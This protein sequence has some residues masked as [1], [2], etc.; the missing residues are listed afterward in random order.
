MK[1]FRKNSISWKQLTFYVEIDNEFISNTC[2]KTE[3]IFF[4]DIFTIL[5]EI[6]I[7]INNENKENRLLYFSIL[8]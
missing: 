4:L 1:S 5:Y 2:V 3:K 7:Y 8:C 6:N